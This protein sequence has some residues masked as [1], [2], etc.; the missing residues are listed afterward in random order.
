MNQREIREADELLKS[1]KE[2]VETER[3]LVE[4]SIKDC[5]Y[6][7][8]KIREY[9]IEHPVAHEEETTENT[10]ETPEIS[11]GTEEDLEAAIKENQ[12][13]YK[14]ETIAGYTELVTGQFKDLSA[15]LS[16][17]SGVV[18]EEND[19]NKKDLVD[20]LVGMVELIESENEIKDL[21]A[22]LNEEY[23]KY[24]DYLASPEYSALQDKKIEELSARL[25]EL[26]KSEK[27]QYVNIKKLK[28]DIRLLKG[29]YDFSFMDN[30]VTIENE[31]ENFF[32]NYRSN[33]VIEKFTSKCK[34]SKVNP[35]VYR[36]FFN[37]EE[38]FLDEHYHPFNNLFLFYCMR[39]IGNADATKQRDEIKL[40][41]NILTKIVYNK[42]PSE[43][44]RQSALNAI[45][46]HHDAYIEAGYTEKFIENN[47]S[48]P[49]H[50]V[51]LEKERQAAE[52]FKDVAISNLNK[53]FN[54][55]LDRSKYDDMSVDDLHQYTIL[56]K[57]LKNDFGVEVTSEMFDMSL[58]ELKEIWNQKSEEKAKEAEEKV[59][60]KV[61][62]SDE[63]QT[64]SNDDAEPSDDPGDATEEASDNAEAPETTKEV[65]EISDS[66]AVQDEVTKVTENKE[67]E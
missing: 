15:L 14:E 34:Q 49:N 39:W 5:G 22:N 64:E 30:R 29:R 65:R 26:E 56:L 57:S 32:N 66:F 13:K 53:E 43:E 10:D 23:D 48:Y 67:E 47:T 54:T 9:V 1:A 61:A 27:N 17:D 63:E 35:D 40:V 3:E 38:K 28:A 20:A 45:M 42:F 8:E 52:N 4:G 12:N 18:I 2:M 25:E 7:P 60:V 31:M 59:Q 41:F 6:D 51:R 44:A 50:P 33:Y 37:I 36:Y 46:A 62:E 21:Q 11:E 24:L 19:D 16:L 55:V 58:D